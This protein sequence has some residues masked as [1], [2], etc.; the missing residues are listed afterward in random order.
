MSSSKDGRPWNTWHSSKRSGFTG[1]RRVASC[2]GT[3]E[4][5]SQRCPYFQSYGKPNK[6]QFKKVSEK[7]VACSCCGYEADSVPCPAKKVWEFNDKTVLVYHCSKHT[8]VA[9]KVLLDITEEAT[10][11]FHENTYAKPSQFPYERLRGMMKEGKSLDEVYAEAKGLANLKKIQNIKQKVIQQDNPVGHSFEALAK[12][13]ESSDRIDKYLLWSVEDGRVSQSKLTA[14]FRS[15]K[16]RIQIASQMQRGDIHPLGSEYC[17]LDAE[18]NKVKDMKTINLTVQHPVL[19]EC[20]IIAS[21]DC[22]TESTQ[23]LCK[24]WRELNN[25]SDEFL[26]GIFRSLYDF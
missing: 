4:C 10:K 20:V 11:F 22:M 2:G 24:F 9:K 13:K 21:M 16:E 26:T 18:H 14:V 3:Y 6:V 1:T 7:I 5:K 19:K 8:C 15:S 12:I 17:F 23:T 25:V